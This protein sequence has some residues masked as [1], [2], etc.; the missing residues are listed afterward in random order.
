MLYQLPDGRTVEISLNDFLESTPEELRSLLAYDCGAVINNPQYGSVINKPGRPDP[1]DDNW[2]E[3][4]I[5]DVSKEEKFKD[6]DYKDE[7]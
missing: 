3:R 2:R 5:Q 6:R 1:D 7:E 4:D